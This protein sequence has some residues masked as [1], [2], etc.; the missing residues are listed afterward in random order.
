[1]TVKST[2]KD[3]FVSAV[4]ATVPAGLWGSL[5]RVNPAI[6]YYHLV[7]DED[8]PHVKHL[9]SFRGVEEFKKDI[10]TFCRSFVP[11][12]LGDLLGCLKG[13]SPIPRNSFLLT[14]DDGFREIYEVIA[15]ILLEKGVPATFFL[16]TACVDNRTM[17]HHNK[18]S[19]L[20]DHLEQ[21]ADRIPE[22][23]ILAML[24]A[25]GAAATT[26]RQGLLSISYRKSYI[27]DE[28]G[29]SLGS[30]FENYL[31]NRRPYLTS[32]QVSELIRMGFS[33]GAHSVDHPLY[34]EL[35]LE[36]QLDQTRR[37]MRFVRE[38]FGLGYGAFAFPHGDRDVSARF[39]DQLSSEV[40]V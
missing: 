8:I 3:G 34:A 1:M 40:D 21:M 29:E 5:T 19:L 32:E 39:F 23:E 30:D 33:I 31:S 26:V 38:R 17:A 36:E 7:A 6:A 11:I 13:S 12:S 16:T 14:F 37:S 28:L 18:I 2:I 24:H 15:P 4:C 27:I 35:S 9:Y 22:R 25:H 20:L 10:D